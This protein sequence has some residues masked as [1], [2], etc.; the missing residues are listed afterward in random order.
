MGNQEID[1]RRVIQA[2]PRALWALLGDSSSWPDWTSIDAFELERAGDADGLGEIRVFKTGRIRVREAIVERNPEQRLSY[3]LLSGLPVREYRADIDLERV[4]DGT[5]LRWHTT[6]RP[7][8][9]GTG[10]IYRSILGLA[11]RRFVDGLA[12]AVEA[13]GG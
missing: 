1:V 9:L 12:A 13:P 2:D 3:A 7:K 10:W 11:T 4:A 8:L 6:F 5:R